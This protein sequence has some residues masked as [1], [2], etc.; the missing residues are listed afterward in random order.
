MESGGDRLGSTG[1]ISGPG[2]TPEGPSAQVGTNKRVSRTRN[3]NF[4]TKH[5]SG[6]PRK[7]LIEANSSGA[8]AEMDFTSGEPLVHGIATQQATNHAY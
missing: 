8:N 6:N 1:R 5:V 2:E 4:K 3:Q 7:R